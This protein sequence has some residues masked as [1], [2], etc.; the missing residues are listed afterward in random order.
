MTKEV[1]AI[2]IKQMPEIENL[3][4]T[5]EEYLEGMA[6][7]IDILELKR[8]KIS[9]IPE[10]L[11]LEVMKITPRVINGTATPEEIVRG[12]MILTPSLREQLTDKN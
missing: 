7:G 6:A 5:V 3:E 8:L 2:E 1:I 4:V 10:D 11:A 9:G 12:I